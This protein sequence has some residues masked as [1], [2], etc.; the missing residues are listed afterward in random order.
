MS[1]WLPKHRAHCIEL[2][3]HARFIPHWSPRDLA[4]YCG[5]RKPQHHA[6]DILTGIAPKHER[7]HGTEEHFPLKPIRAAKVM[8]AKAWFMERIVSLATT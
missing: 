8:P 2:A 1:D 3:T 7:E 6:A 4:T 5:G